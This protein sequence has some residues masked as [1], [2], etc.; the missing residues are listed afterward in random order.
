M[1]AA[2]ALPTFSYPAGAQ[3][4]PEP[5]DVAELQRRAEEFE[6]LL[7]KGASRSN[8]DV[9]QS[10]PLTLRTSREPT[11]YKISVGDVISLNFP[12]APEFDQAL[13]AVMP[14]GFVSLKGVG[15][16]WIAG[17]NLPEA[18]E[19]IE[20]EYG[21]FLRDPEVSV[22]L[23]QYE[24]PYFVAFGQ[25]QAPGKYE[26]TGQTTAAQAL[27]IAGGFAESA[28]NRQL[29]VLRSVD[30]AWAEAIKVDARSLLRGGH[31][32]EDIELQPG[33]MLFVPKSTMSSI[34]KYVPRISMG[35]GW[36]LTD[37]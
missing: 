27:G 24:K 12:L 10:A 16:V 29:I 11:R 19:A 8:H 2:L 35:I 25:V 26:L 23:E 1:A 36:R 14:D 22:K 31:L 33:D 20:Q 17:K 7:G 32:D 30:G 3:T 37:R 18:R 9:P 28:K 34:A 5:A 13:V 6:S 4:Q 15:D 21:K